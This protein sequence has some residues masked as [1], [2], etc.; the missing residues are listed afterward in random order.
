ML[1]RYPDFLTDFD[2]PDS[3]RDGYTTRFIYICT[4]P[5]GTDAVDMSENEAVA[6]ADEYENTLRSIIMNCEKTGDW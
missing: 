3:T 4:K 6:L 1:G 2:T 5:D